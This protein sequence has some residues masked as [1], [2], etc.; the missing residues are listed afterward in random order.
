MS[1][2]AASSAAMISMITE[3]PT[4]TAPTEHKI[5][6]ASDYQ[7]AARSLLPTPLY[8]YLASGTD[9]EQTLAENESAFKYWY[10]RPRVMRPVGSISTAT[11]L[12]GQ[13]LS[14][15]VFVSPAGVHA[16]CDEVHG[17][18]AS[19]RAAQ[20][21][22]TLFGLSQH[23]TRS[24]EQVAGA[25]AAAQGRNANLWYQCYILKDRDMTLRLVRRAANAGYRGIFLTV[26]SVRFGFREA[27]ARNGWS[28][29]PEPHRLVN[30]DEEIAN[31]PQSSESK[32]SSWLSPEASVDK[33]KIYAGDEDAW[34]QN[35]EQLFEQN[36]TWEDVCWLKREACHDLPLIIKGIMT[37]ED[38]VEA[39]KAGADG[40]MVSNHGGRGLDGALAAID[41]LPEVVAAVGDKV[42]VLM[43]SGVRRGT[44][45]LKALALGASAVGIGKPVFFA[46]AVGGE[47]A[48]VNLLQILQ[49]EVEAA[50]AICGVESVADAKR[51]LVTRHPN[52]GVTRYTRSKL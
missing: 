32:K 33:T 41:A 24:I 13:K 9:D 8:E 22:G 42:P 39:V 48:V 50:M 20:R 26:D 43:D 2:E 36:P 10:L 21:A 31:K 27:D 23:A 52:G 4:V 3:A 1:E 38:A 46:L 40:V 34:D 14:L 37:A 47:N 12:F 28:A 11:T 45:V 44:D 17:E 19:A 5:C 25:C 51:S 49:R 16:L 15:P 6:N 35:T 18:C 7:I 29:L 30:Y